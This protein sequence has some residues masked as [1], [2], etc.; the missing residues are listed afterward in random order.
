MSLCDSLR[1]Q[2]QASD[3]VS[4]GF[5]GV[6]D[7]LRR[8]GGAVLRSLDSEILTCSLGD[9]GAGMLLLDIRDLG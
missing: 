2:R 5:A 4:W 3:T 7:R 8:P 6:G 9:G 1:V